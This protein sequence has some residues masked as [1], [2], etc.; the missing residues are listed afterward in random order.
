[1]FTP[2]RK[3]FLEL[4]ERGNL[5][6]VYRE[7]VA[8]LDTP[9]SAYAKLGSDRPYAFL[10]ESA[11]AGRF[12]RYSFLGVDPLLVLT[13][14]DGRMRIDHRDGRREEGPCRGDPL[15]ELERLMGRFQPVC[16]EELPFFSGGAVGFLGYEAATYFEPAIPR[17]RCADLHT[18]D[19]LFL[20]ADSVMV[21]DHHERR[22][23]LVAHAWVEGDP[24]AA[25]LE[26]TERL[27]RM[28]AT[29]SHGVQRPS[30]LRPEAVGDLPFR[31]NMTPEEYVRMTE[32]MAEYI[33]AGD[34][35]QVVPSQRLEVEFRGDPLDLYRALRL[36]NPSPYM[37]CLRLG[38]FS[39]VGSSPEVHVRCR[40]GKALMRPIAGTRPR[41][42]NPREE[43]SVVEEL[44]SDPKER[45]EHVMLLD[46]ARNDLGRVCSYDSVRVA[47]FLVVEKYS[48]VLHIVSSV[49][50]RLQPGKNPFDVLRATFPAG[51]VTGAPKVRAMQII[52][53]LE[54]TERGPYAGVVGYFGFS[55]AFDSCIAIRTVLLQRG[56]AF[57][58][59]G[60]GL[61]ADSTPWGEYRESLNKAKAGLKALALANSLR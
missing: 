33:R 12:G 61:V 56:K 30:L 35:F 49:E 52:A 47:D 20:L 8:D 2:E 6:P 18:P 41:P 9:V 23:K 48:H 24:D 38:D 19:L 27:D 5:I 26:A 17:A 36:V 11:E 40:E 50:G 16:V 25:Y 3:A 13:V 14:R 57:L 44:L 59:A 1:M 58:Q 42:E 10:L 54:P 46:L 28:Q 37:F 32:R 4:A 39:L 43:E 45:A 51:T 22:I 53:E 31:A 7:I 55:G 60:G 34:I 21:F 29:L 15:R